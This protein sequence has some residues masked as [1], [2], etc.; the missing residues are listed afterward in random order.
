MT[1]QYKTTCNIQP[2]YPTHL[3][4]KHFFG[5]Q[6]APKTFKKI[7]GCENKDVVNEINLKDN[8]LTETA[9]YLEETLADEENISMIIT[10][11]EIVKYIE[12]F[13]QKWVLVSRE[14]LT[15]LV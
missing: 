5:Y 2:W 3:C 7:R 1:P 15:L 9:I 12:A 8:A 10:L 4:H 13:A 11:P 14:E 6:W